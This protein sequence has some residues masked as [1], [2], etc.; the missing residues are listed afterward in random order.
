M[1]ILGGEAEGSS[2]HHPVGFESG[3]G[4]TG[5]WLVLMLIAL[6]GALLW[7]GISPATV[8]EGSS[9]QFCGSRRRLAHRSRWVADARCGRHRYS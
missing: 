3:V 2:G 5:L 7:T 1:A 8:I 9:P 4:N 6:T